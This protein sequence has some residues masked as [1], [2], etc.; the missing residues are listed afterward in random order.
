MNFRANY[1]FLKIGLI[2]QFSDKGQIFMWGLLGMVGSFTEAFPWIVL[3]S[4]YGDISGYSTQGIVLY[5]LLNNVSW[6][7]TGGTFSWGIS[8]IIKSGSLSGNLLRPIFPFS[9]MIVSEQAWKISG[10]IFSMPMHILLAWLIIGIPADLF[11]FK[12]LLLWIL[13]LPIAAI[14][15]GEIEFIKGVSAFFLIRTNGIINLIENIRDLFSGAIAP[16]YL[17]PPILQNVSKGLPFLYIFGF[18]TLVLLGEI[19]TQEYIDGI[20]VSFVWAIILFIVCYILYK[21]GI[22]KYESVGS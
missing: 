3:G 7:I 17:L 13:T 22:K 21:L 15:F 20:I 18:P 9:K 8:N 12:N 16:L 1:T 10:F 19:T 2:E 5:Y 4:V 14:I 11:E 6:F